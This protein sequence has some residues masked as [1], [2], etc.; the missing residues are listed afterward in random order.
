MQIAVKHTVQNGYWQNFLSKKTLVF[1][2]Y[3]RARYTYRL[4][5]S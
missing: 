2:I 5:L 4:T 3:E 1:C